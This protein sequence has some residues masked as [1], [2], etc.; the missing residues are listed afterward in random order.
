MQRFRLPFAVP[1]AAA[2]AASLDGRVDGA[3]A[4]GRAVRWMLAGALLACVLCPAPARAQGDAALDVQVTD[5]ETGGPLAGATVRLDGV[6]RAVSDTAGR[7]FLY[8]LAPGHHQLDVAM[9]GR[10]VVSPMIEI[11]GGEVL[12]LEVVLDADAVPLPRID[13]PPPPP[14]GGS[15]MHPRKRG[16]GRFI[17]RDEIVRSRVTQLSELLVR[18][19]A[20]QPNGRLRQSHCDPRIVADGIVLSGSTIDIIPVQDLEA[21]QVYNGDVPV[22]FGGSVGG[23]CGVIAVW[24]RHK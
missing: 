10:R 22:E 2:P 5:G 3:R 14:E 1:A 12:N 16:A 9:V 23:V 6:M 18:I 15:G 17:G 19:G 8:G 24:T 11:A 20:L 13:V 21:V 4:T 7:A